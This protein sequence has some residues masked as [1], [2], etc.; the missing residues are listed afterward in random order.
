MNLLS[1]LL[2]TAVVAGAEEPHLGSLSL[3]G[4]DVAV[5]ADPRLRE[6]VDQAIDA[7]GIVRVVGALGVIGEHG[8]LSDFIYEGISPTL[9]AYCGSRVAISTSD[10]SRTISDRIMEMSCGASDHQAFSSW[11]TMPRFRRWVYM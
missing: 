3:G 7:P 11:R 4:V 5:L 9:A 2:K 8:V 6:A 1:R 10:A